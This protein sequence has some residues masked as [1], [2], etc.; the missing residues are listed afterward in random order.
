M[1]SALYKELFSVPDPVL[2]S[3]L[4]NGEGQRRRCAD[5]SSPAVFDPM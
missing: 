2:I 3:F 1:E 5:G 4:V